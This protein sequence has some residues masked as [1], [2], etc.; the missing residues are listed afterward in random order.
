LEI[1]GVLLDEIIKGCSTP[2]SKEHLLHL[3]V[4]SLRDTEELLSLVGIPEA[5]QFI[6][7]NPHPRLW[8]LLAEASLKKLDL[9][10]AES[11]FVR[12]TNYPGIQLIKRL[13][14]IQLEALQRAEICAFFGEFDE[15]EKLYLDVDRRDLAIDLR[16]K[17]CDWFRTV[18]LYKMGPGISDQQ[19]EQAWR[20]IGNSFANTKAWES[21]KE[22]YEKSHHIEGLMD[23]LYNMEQYD[24]LEAC[25]Y[26][27]PEKSPLLGKLGQMLATVGVCDQAVAAYLKLGDVKSAVTTCINLRQWG[28]AVELAQKY[29]MPQ[30][31]ALLAKHAAHLLQEGKLPEAVE[32]QKKAG[33]Y[34]DAARLMTKLAECETEKKSDHLRIKQLYVLAGLLV[35]EHIEKQISLTGGNR[36]TILSQLSTED[37]VLYETISRTY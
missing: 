9:E 36:A 17:L 22:Y 12:C 2:N 8:R 26:K 35:E 19:M 33:R 20:E 6:E 25:I 21:A 3:R 27:L 34:L 24:Q 37:A 16:Q 15:A 13:N 14:T 23:S 7:D 29:K 1:T 18:Q 4:K 32:L 28:L 30:I 11:A 10:T 5:K 31:S